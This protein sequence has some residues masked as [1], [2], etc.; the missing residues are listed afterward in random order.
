MP[1][2]LMMEKACSREIIVLS[3]EDL[4]SDMYA[5]L[6]TMFGVRNGKYQS[7]E[8]FTYYCL[9]LVEVSC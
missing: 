9:Y 1:A 6:E 7:R 5:M 4:R 3:D 8:V 2:S